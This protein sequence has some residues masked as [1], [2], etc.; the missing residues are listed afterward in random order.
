[1]AAHYKISQLDKAAGIPA[2]T[3]R[4][5]ER[6]RLVVPETR[7]T[8]NYRLYGDESLKK[9]M[10]IRATQAIVFTLED[11]KSLLATESGRT[12]TCGRVQ[13][14]IEARLTDIEDKLKD[15]RHVRKVL[16]SALVECQQHKKSDCCHVVTELRAK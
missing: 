8:G 11:I 10:F 5:Y 4:Y 1:M 9:V 16:K 6:I 12:P 3:V 14:L 7:S 2:T 13:K 15:L